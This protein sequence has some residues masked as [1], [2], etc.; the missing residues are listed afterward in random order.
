MAAGWAEVGRRGF[1]YG[2]RHFCEFFFSRACLC[3]GRWTDVDDGLE[4]L[5][6]VNEEL[7]RLGFEPEVFVHAPRLE[8]VVDVDVKTVGLDHGVP[9]KS[10]Y[11]GKPPEAFLP[12]YYKS[13]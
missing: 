9:L 4:I 13:S 2:L 1:G 11:K 10:L 7:S 3:V 12:Q 8:V 6:H 5:V